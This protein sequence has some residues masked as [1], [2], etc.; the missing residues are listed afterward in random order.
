MFC[1]TEFQ[2]IAW[3]L[4]FNLDWVVGLMV[5]TVHWHASPVLASQISHWPVPARLNL[6]Q[7]LG[8]S[9]PA[10]RLVRYVLFSQ[11]YG[12]W[13]SLSAGLS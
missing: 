7:L 13:L 2:H 1:M 10:S 5:G 3:S 9:S 11:P 6:L 8:G 12:M 4:S